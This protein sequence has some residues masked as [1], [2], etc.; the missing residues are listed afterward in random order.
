M[1]TV[2]HSALVV[3]VQSCDWIDMRIGECSSVDEIKKWLDHTY[4]H[5]RTQFAEVFRKMGQ[6]SVN[7]RAIGIHLNNQPIKVDEE[8]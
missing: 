8:K 3:I 1:M 6:I 2:P 5:D 4:T 7:A